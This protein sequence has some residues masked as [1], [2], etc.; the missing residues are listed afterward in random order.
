MIAAAVAWLA[1]N[2]AVVWRSLPWLLALAGLLGTLWFRSAA[3]RCELARQADRTA[4]EKAKAD[5]L[6]DAQRRSDAIVTEQA[7]ALAE[8]AARAST[9]Q[10]RIRVVPVTTACADSPAV[11]LGIDGVRDILRA[12][13]GSPTKA[14]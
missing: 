13:G 9:I 6:E 8:T 14:Q 3:D 5:A 12:P 11:R 2:R 10:E 1:A 4:A 7:K